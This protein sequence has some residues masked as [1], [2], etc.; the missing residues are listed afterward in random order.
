MQAVERHP[1]ICV[2]FDVRHTIRQH[3]ASSYLHV[4]DRRIP[5]RGLDVCGGH[6][7]IAAVLA[8]SARFALVSFIAFVAFIA[9]FAL[10]AFIAFVALRAL[11]PAL[12]GNPLLTPLASCTGRAFDVYR[13]RIA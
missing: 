9:R 1:L 12:T 13:S 10:I 6:V 2:R 11:C 5:Q 8:G 4:L 7:R 3:A